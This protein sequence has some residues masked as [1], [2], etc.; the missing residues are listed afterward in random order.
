M[1][2]LQSYRQKELI[3]DGNAY[4][5]T[6]TYHDGMLKMYTTHPTQAVDGT[7]EYHMSRVGG[8][9]LTGDLIPASGD[10][11]HSGT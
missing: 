3:Y 10:L 1:H 9:A 11:L 2:Q 6:S 4:T 5:I 7:T 8:W